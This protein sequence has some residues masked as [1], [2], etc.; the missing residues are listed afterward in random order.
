MLQSTMPMILTS[1]NLLI[2]VVILLIILAFL[3]FRP[4]LTP[5]TSTKGSV[6]VSMTADNF[7]PERITIP[8][9]TT[10]TFVNKDKVARWPASNLHPTHTL[11]P[12]FDPKEPVGVGKSWSFKFDKV[13]SWKYHDH[14]S[15]YITGTITV[16]Q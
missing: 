13:G 7:E 12:E 4:N 6:T 3:L 15:P 8:V 11:Y 5:G 1:R 9:G 16:T 2:G 14:L 10:V